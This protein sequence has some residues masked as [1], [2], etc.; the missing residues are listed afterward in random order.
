MELVLL[1]HGQSEWNLKN[2]FTGWVDVDL[3]DVGMIEAIES[4]G[5]MA[6][7]GVIP[8]VVHTSL[9][10]RHPNRR[11]IAAGDG[12]PVDPGAA[13]LAPQRAPLRGVAR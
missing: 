10:K 9:Q 13:Q 3:T 4:G 1:R 11:G 2:I 6:E 5:L 7:A 12:P 8:D